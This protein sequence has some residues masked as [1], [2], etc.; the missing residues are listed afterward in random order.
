M[1]L[2]LTSLRGQS[3]LGTTQGHQH[4]RRATLRSRRY[5]QRLAVKGT[6]GARIA[7]LYIEVPAVHEATHVARVHREDA[8]NAS[9]PLGI[10]AGVGKTVGCGIHGGHP[11][12]APARGPNCGGYG[13]A[14]PTALHYD[15]PT[16]YEPTR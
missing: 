3:R 5:L 4:F 12:M 2:I 15:A 1:F 11:C 14:A 7:R 6:R 16:P 10:R 9:E 8:L 13:V